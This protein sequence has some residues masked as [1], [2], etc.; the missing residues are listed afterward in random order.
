MVI[1]HLLKDRILLASLSDTIA[2]STSPSRADNKNNC[3][4][5]ACSSPDA[6]LLAVLYD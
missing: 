1:R 2:V 4:H 6:Y 5:L 3:P